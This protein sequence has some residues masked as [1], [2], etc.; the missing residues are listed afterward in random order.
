MISQHSIV[1]LALCALVAFGV[2]SRAAPAEPAA[3]PPSASRTVRFGDLDLGTARGAKAL[4]WRIRTA[5]RSVCGVYERP[6]DF[7]PSASFDACVKSA[8]DSAVAAV[9]SPAFSAYYRERRGLHPIFT[10]AAR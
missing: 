9:A 5:A 8:M 2:E 7:L 3:H 1:A 6:D 10:A 4:Y